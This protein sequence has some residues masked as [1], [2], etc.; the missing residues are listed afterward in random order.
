MDQELMA[1]KYCVKESEG[2]ALFLV[3]GNGEMSMEQAQK[4]VCNF[5][6]A[7]LKREFME[8][9]KL[10]DFKLFPENDEVNAEFGEATPENSSLI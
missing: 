2:G 1:R 7:Q 10:S 3:T 4:S 5:K 9:E 8:T 6:S